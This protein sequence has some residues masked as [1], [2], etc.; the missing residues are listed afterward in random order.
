MLDIVIFGNG[1]KED[2]EKTI[3][4]ISYQ[5]VS[6]SGSIYLVDSCKYPEIISY[7]DNLSIQSI[8]SKRCSMRIILKKLS[9]TYVYFIDAGDVIATPLFLYEFFQFLKSNKKKYQAFFG[10]YVIG[11]PKFVEEKFDSCDYYFPMIYQREYLN[12]KCNPL[13]KEAFFFYINHCLLL[14]NRCLDFDLK[15]CIVFTQ[16]HDFSSMW[17]SY[18]EPLDLLVKQYEV[19]CDMIVHRVLFFIY[20]YYLE[21]KCIYHYPLLKSLLKKFHY[22]PELLLSYSNDFDMVKLL[23]ANITFVRFIELVLEGVIC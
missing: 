18:L 15:M 10:S 1:N 16:H 9:S 5:I 17:F 21:H 20:L 8:V 11:N 19:Q 12:L 23:G 6:L 13:E 3:L 14:E 4:S 22:Q 2:I 7:Y